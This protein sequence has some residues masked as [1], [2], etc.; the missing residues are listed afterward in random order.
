MRVKM[1]VVL[2]AREH[3]WTATGSLGETSPVTNSHTHVILHREGELNYIEG[4][5]A[6]IQPEVLVTFCAQG[7]RGRHWSKPDGYNGSTCLVEWKSN[8]LWAW[9]MVQPCSSVKRMEFWVFIV[10]NGQWSRW[11][12]CPAGVYIRRSSLVVLG[13][14]GPFHRHSHFILLP[15][16]WAY[17]HLT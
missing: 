6:S 12:H 8:Q 16:S 4:S 9:P 3:S 14:L 17:C 2:W 7:W 10:Y 11:Y 1:F 5:R 15:Q 13:I